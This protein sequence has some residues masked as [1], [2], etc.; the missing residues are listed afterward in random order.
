MALTEATSVKY[1]SPSVKSIFQSP[2]RPGTM[3]RSPV[4]VMMRMTKSKDMATSHSFIR[5]SAFFGVS[6]D[7]LTV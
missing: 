1:T 7:A 4:V 2:P 6:K 5:R 3:N